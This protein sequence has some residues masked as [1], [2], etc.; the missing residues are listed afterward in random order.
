MYLTDLSKHRD[1]GCS[2]TLIELGPFRILIDSGS[3]PQKMGNDALPDFSKIGDGT[4]D[5]IIITHSHLDHIGSLP[6]VYRRQTQAQIITSLPSQTLIPRMLR[7]SVR[8]MM[9]QR[10]EHNI[11]EY[12]LF[13]NSEIGDLERALF[14]MP[15]DRTR[16]FEKDGHSLEVTLYPAGHIAG[17]AGCL[18]KYKHRK[19]FF[20]GDVLFEDQYTIPGAKFPAEILDTLIMETTRGTTERLPENSRFNECNRLL[21]I[22]NHT[23]DRG[24]SCLIP[25]FALGRMQE[26]LCLLHYARTQ[27]LL[28]KCPIYCSGLGLDLIEYFDTISRKTGL[29]NFRKKIATQLKVEALK[30]TLYPGEN[31]SLGIY[32]LSSGMMLPNT[33]SYAAAASMVEH[34]HNSICFVGYCDPETP[35]GKLLSTAHEESFLFKELNYVGKIRATINKFDLS[36]HADRNELINY[37]TKTS[38][39]AIVLTHGE[40]SAREWFEQ[41]LTIELP[42]AKVI[43][44]EPGKTLLV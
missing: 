33:P 15:Y 7:N 24:G 34:P 38:P 40:A 43:N 16:V 35:G 37:A 28:P 2:C 3:H 39:R 4:L 1:V 19:I 20:T 6:V 21:E 12:P 14:T 5:I 29:I 25:V 10:E 13:T 42:R 32:L 30:T 27:D 26:I 17:A 36:A 41:E 23:L 11:L 8:V 22:I 44:P 9:A 18:F 31:A